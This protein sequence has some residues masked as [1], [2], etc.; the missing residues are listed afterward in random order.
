MITYFSTDVKRIRPIIRPFLLSI[1]QLIRPV[2]AHLCIRVSKGSK[3]SKGSKDLV[4][5]KNIFAVTKSDALI[6][7]I[8]RIFSE[9]FDLI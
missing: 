8:S 7:L 3:G 9:R 5:A 2:C 4:T 6:Q 1:D